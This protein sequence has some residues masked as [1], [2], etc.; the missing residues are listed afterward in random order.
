M[1]D[2]PEQTVVSFIIR[3]GESSIQG[4]RNEQEDMHVAYPE[5]D[6]MKKAPNEDEFLVPCDGTK[7][8]ANSDTL[9][10][11]AVFDG[12]GG[13]RCSMYVA[14]NLP[15]LVRDNFFRNRNIKLAMKDA[16]E[17]VE[18]NFCAY[19]KKRKDVMDGT[20]AAVM[21]IY[22]NVLNIVN[23]GDTEI[24]LCRKGNA[25]VL[26]EVHTPK[27]NEK[28]A[29]RI[30]AGGGEIYYDRLA[31]PSKNK[32]NFNI[33]V[34]RAIGDILFKLP[35]HTNGKVPTLIADPYLHTEKLCAED[36]FI[37]IA[38]DGLWDVMTY[39]GAIDFVI[40]KLEET[41]DPQFVAQLLTDEGYR[42]GSRDN[43]T[44]L[45]VTLKSWEQPQPPQ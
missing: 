17:E 38:C 43:I 39:Q 26:T 15:W 35:E 33:A 2:K 45:I 19:A 4:R 16:L 40:S 22:Q 3:Y 37:I 27:R 44:V 34:S 7:I 9:S 1:A 30:V 21:T 31:H 8:S 13:S 12:H 25:H 41:D 23:V 10:F 29:D 28:E 5:L 18:K 42:K 11:F 6:K 24:V 36:D 14:E 32:E 20:T